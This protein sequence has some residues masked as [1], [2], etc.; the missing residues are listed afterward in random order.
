M[1]T[2]GK[3]EMFIDENLKLKIELDEDILA[4]YLIPEKEYEDIKKFSEEQ[5]LEYLNK[6]VQ[7]IG[8]WE[9]M[10]NAGGSLLKELKIAEPKENTIFPIKYFEEPKKVQFP[11]VLIR[12][13]VICMTSKDKNKE[14]NLMEFS[15]EWFNNLISAL[16]GVK[17]WRTL[18]NCIKEFLS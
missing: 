13:Y 1:S 10:I 14:I 15:I 6:L 9:K 16:E 18:K 2:N 8:K 12:K 17:K 3:H 11:D 4:I 5:A 7:E